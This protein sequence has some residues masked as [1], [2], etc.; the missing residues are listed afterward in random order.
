MDYLVLLMEVYCV[1]HYLIHHYFAGHCL[2]DAV[3]DAAVV[4]ASLQAPLPLLPPH[5]LL[6]AAAPAVVVVSGFHFDAAQTQDTQ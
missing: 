3:A 2:A 1:H 4:G 6:L 5:S